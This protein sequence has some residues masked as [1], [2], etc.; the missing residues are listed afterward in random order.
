MIEPSACD[1][2]RYPVSWLDRTGV[3]FFFAVL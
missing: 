3:D 1:A 2:L